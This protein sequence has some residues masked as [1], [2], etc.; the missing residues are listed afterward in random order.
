MGCAPLKNLDM[1]VRRQA[2]GYPQ[3]LNMPIWIYFTKYKFRCK[4]MQ[5]E[6]RTKKAVLLSGIKLDTKTN[7]YYVVTIVIPGELTH[8][9][10]KYWEHKHFI[11][12]KRRVVEYA[13]LEQ[14]E[15]LK[16]QEEFELYKQLTGG[17]N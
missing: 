8:I 17:S 14:L 2:I 10:R 6:T 7:K 16:Q 11:P 3:D 9:R 5:Y 4:N 12:M 15:Q 1:A 13:T